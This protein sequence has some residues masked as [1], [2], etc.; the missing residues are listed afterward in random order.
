MD[1]E[2]NKINKGIETYTQDMVRVIHDNKDGAIR[3]IIQE[4][5]L[6]EAEKTLS[7][8]SKRNKIF[9]ALGVVL[10]LLGVG[11]VVF[12]YLTKE[13][14]SISVRPKFAPLIYHETAGV[15]EVGGL[16]KDKITEDIWLKATSTE[17]KVGGVEGIY[18]TERKSAVGFRRLLALIRAS[19][20][21][22]QIE[23][24]SDNILFGVVNV[25]DG[26]SLK[27]PKD[28]NLADLPKTPKTETI[29]VAG[30]PVTLNTSA[31]FKTGTVEFVNT[32]AREEAKEAISKFLDGVDLTTSKIKVVGTYSVERPWIKNEEIAEA[33]RAMGVEI[34][35]EVLN[36]KYSADEVKSIIVESSAKGV[37]VLDLY[38]ALEIDSMSKDELDSNINAT[39]GIQYFAEAKTKSHTIT[40]TVEESVEPAKPEVKD[41]IP[42]TGKDL[43]ILL[44]VR[45]FNDVFNPLRAWENKMFSDLHG[46]FGIPVN[47]YT[48]YLLTRG[49]EDGII[50]NKNARILYNTEGKIVMMYVYADENSV[51]IA[52]TEEAVKE[53]MLRLAASKV[54]K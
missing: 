51:I 54:R 20:T 30:E 6:R 10:I 52:N 28:T 42:K 38:S 36:E 39:Q 32:T 25:E 16:T 2:N 37:S 17:V 11:A 7:P 49:F 3:K 47:A 34:L 40:K 5:E 1:N 12:W 22:S 53:V 21:S 44:K 29:E 14:G 41:Y 26:K 19:I 35:M 23:A 50:Q 13:E 9:M 27:D 18:L 46:F 48:S 15:V 33:R 43:F 4:Q 24:I 45:S 8:L 31:F